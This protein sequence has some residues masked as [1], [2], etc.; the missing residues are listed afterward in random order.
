MREGTEG[1]TSRWRKQHLSLTVM[2]LFH[3]VS[4]LNIS[5]SLSC[6]SSSFSYSMSCLLFTGS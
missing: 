2:W 4:L 6:I 5:Y 1:Q 3:L